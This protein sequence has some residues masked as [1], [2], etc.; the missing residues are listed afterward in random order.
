MFY[1]VKVNEKIKAKN[2]L[3]VETA[4]TNSASIINQNIVSTAT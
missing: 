4:A 1:F 2:A 3:K